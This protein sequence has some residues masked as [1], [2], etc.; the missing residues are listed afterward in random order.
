MGWACGSSLLI[1]IAL[2]IFLSAVAETVA[3]PTQ[4]KQN[5]QNAQDR[6][7]VGQEQPPEITRT[8]IESVAIKALD[9]IAREQETARQE[10][11]TKEKRW[12]PPAPDW[13]LVYVTVVYVIAA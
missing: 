8:P 3:L 4:P 2:G 13:A 1:P 7:R 9:A 12:W 6:L 5:E 10:Q 11:E